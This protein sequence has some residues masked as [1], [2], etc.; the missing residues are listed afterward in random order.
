MVT[1]VEIV[2]SAPYD[3]KGPRLIEG[4]PGIGLVGTIAA[5]YLVEK[6]QMEQ[7][8]YITSEK[9]PA[10]A[11][12]HD[13]VP[14]HPARI[15]KSKKYNLLVLFSEFIVP[16]ATVYPLSTEILKWSK[17][18][19]V[20]EIHSLGGI[21]LKKGSRETFGIASTPDMVKRLE[22]AEVKTIKEG[23][24][25][26]VS[27]ILL[28][29]CAT[30]KFPASSILAQSNTSYMDPGAA[31]RAL[32]C[33]SAVIGLEINTNELAAEAKL[34]EGKMKDIIQNAQDSHTQHY[35]AAESLGAMYG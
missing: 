3:L 28:A 8:G 5:S 11:A 19:G 21:N 20:S 32:A 35:K 27:G 33:L 15:Y 18:K 34:I 30:Q 10:L 14:L 24:T 7:L 29:E 25:T 9:F 12:I 17:A 6:L 23:A 26:G 16:L 1:K 31:A 2:E 13:Y 4:F 22:K